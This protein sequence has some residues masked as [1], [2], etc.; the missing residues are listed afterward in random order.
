M[1]N[2]K[3]RWNKCI[4]HIV[5]RSNICRNKMETHKIH[6]ASLFSCFDYNIVSKSI[7]L[8]GNYIVAFL[9]PLY[10][11]KTLSNM[12]QLVNFE[13]S[14]HNDKRK[15]TLI[16]RIQWQHGKQQRWQRTHLTANQSPMNLSFIFHSLSLSY[17][18]TAP[19]LVKT[20]HM[21]VRFLFKYCS[22]IMDINNCNNMGIISIIRLS[23]HSFCT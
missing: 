15:R 20:L 3:D 4:H 11:A 19:I 18:L 17:S 7:Q 12:T 13:W 14:S 5:F 6:F 22:V 8:I 9:W 10:F 16:L 21:C 2:C 1:L 23:H